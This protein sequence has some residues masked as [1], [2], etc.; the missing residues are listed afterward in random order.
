MASADLQASLPSIYPQL[1]KGFDTFCVKPNQ[2]IDDAR[3]ME[4]FL[5]ELVTSFEKL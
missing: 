5:D 1:E 4:A 2:F 3:D